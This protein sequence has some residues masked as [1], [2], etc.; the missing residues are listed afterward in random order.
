MTLQLEIKPKAKELIMRKTDGNFTLD[1]H[2]T[3]SYTG[4]GHIEPEVKLGKPKD[5]CYLYEPVEMDGLTCFKN[6][7][8]CFSNECVVMMKKFLNYRCIGIEPKCHG[9]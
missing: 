1:M 3:L 8:H 2:E 7:E 5:H 6:V 4:H 9:Q